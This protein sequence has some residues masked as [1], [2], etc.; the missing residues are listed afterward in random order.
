MVATLSLSACGRTCRHV[1][2]Y[3]CDHDM[4]WK[5]CICGEVK[6]GTEK[7]HNFVGGVCS[8]C[9]QVEFVEGLE[10]SKVIKGTDVTY[11]VKSYSG[12][13]TNVEIP[14]AICGKAVTGVAYRA[15]DGC[16]DVVDITL[17]DTL[18]FF[19]DYAFEGCTSLNY[20]E[21]NGFKYLGNIFNPYLYLASSTDDSRTSIAIKD[22][23]QFVGTNAF[24][25][26][27]SLNEVVIPTSV[28]GFAKGAF[29]GCKEGTLTFV[30]YMGTANEW[31]EIYFSEPSA[32]AIYYSKN[33]YLSGERIK[34]LVLSVAEI[35]A[36]SFFDCNF[37]TLK[38]EEGVVSIGQSAF[39]ACNYRITSPETKYFTNL[40]L[41]STLTTIGH[42]AF[43]NCSNLRTVTAT[44]SLKEIGTHAF[45]NCHD[46]GVIK[47]NGK[48]NDWRA[49]DFGYEWSFGATRL[50]Q[51]RCSNGS[52]SLSEA[53]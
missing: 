5:E 30:N 47:Y 9:T 18:V 31:A 24:Y 21:E 46:L 45:A 19:G 25:Y 41:P 37:E 23:V 36:Y 42:S 12:S 40:I 34:N 4:H 13:A 3:T 22:G 27:K 49:I 14:S 39:Q 28:K 35:S 1:Y 38:L 50:S 6:K 44:T 48:T 11:H 15:F 8:E 52:I 33:L 29:E 43:R 7:P 26:H 53:E 32:N 10:F 20:K 17:P 2:Y 16:K 51:I